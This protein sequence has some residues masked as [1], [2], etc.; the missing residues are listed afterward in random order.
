MPI[1]EVVTKQV[2][3]KILESEVLASGSVTSSG[4]IIDTANYDN[5]VYFFMDA[6]SV[7]SGATVSLEIS[8]GDNSLLSD[9]AL[10]PDKNLVYGDDGDVI[11]D[12]EDI[13]EGD[14][15]PKEGVFGTKRYLRAAV[16]KTGAGTARVAVYA[17]VNPEIAATDQGIP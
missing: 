15:C 17:V 3:L 12:G 13:D 7:A 6:D 1:K 4:V 8:H 5:G 11:I 16:E 2:V 9:A 10:V 14:A